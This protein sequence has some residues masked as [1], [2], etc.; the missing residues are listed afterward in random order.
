MNH[1]EA[2][3]LLALLKHLDG[4]AVQDPD[5]LM[6]D[7]QLLFEAAKDV[8]RSGSLPLDLQAIEDVLGQIA[9]RYAD[10]GD[11]DDEPA[12]DINDAPTGGVL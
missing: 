3:S 7:V 5:H 10:A 2:E 1:R 6:L 4:S 8:P 11:W 9:Q 12:R